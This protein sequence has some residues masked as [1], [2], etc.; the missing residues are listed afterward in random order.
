MN[1]FSH[2]PKQDDLRRIPLFATLP[3]RE[4]KLLT[5]T[6]DLVDVRPGTEL[7]REGETGREFFAIVEGEVEI[8]QGGHPIA[9]EEA[10]DFF[11]EIALLYDIP[12]TATVTAKAPSTLFVLTAPAFRSLLAERFA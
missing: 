1:I 12:R 3:R 10:G 5:R 8:S 6:A 7:I 9:T 11:G 2:D 4:F